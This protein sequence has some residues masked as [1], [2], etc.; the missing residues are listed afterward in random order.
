MK[1]WTL[2]GTPAVEMLDELA[3]ILG[4][5]GLALL[6]TDTIY[7]LHTRAADDAAIGRL[8]EAKGRDEKKP[9]VVIGE[10]I[11]QFLAL[12]AVV[13]ASLRATL[14][15][16]WPAPLTAVLPLTAPIAASRGAASLA[17]RV[18]AVPWLRTLAG[19][20]GALAS[21]SANRSGEPPV[22]SPDN[23]AS[24]VVETLDAIVDAGVCSGEPSTIVDFTGSSPRIVR[25]GDARFSQIVWKTLRKSL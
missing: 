21:T 8:A 24:D 10:S 12:G 20:T 1:R 17:V 15:S 16:L 19:R 6:P 14:D 7:G 3:T 9:F 4:A 23:L 22:T 2:A 11:D 5:G 25:E 18:P 13:P